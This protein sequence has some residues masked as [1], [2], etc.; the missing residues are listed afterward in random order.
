MATNTQTAFGLEF[1]F[2]IIIDLAQ[3]NMRRLSLKE[4]FIGS[5]LFSKLCS[6]VNL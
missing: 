3:I 5:R 4:L 6:K 1:L 2:N